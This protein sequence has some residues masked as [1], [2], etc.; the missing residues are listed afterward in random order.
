MTTTVE[1]LD[2]G[3]T[4]WRSGTPVP[5]S[6]LDT[7]YMVEHPDGGVIYFNNRKLFY[8]ANAGAVW[9]PLIQTLSTHR[10]WFT[11]FFIPDEIT[12]CD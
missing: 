6:S 10:T 5:A 11:A 9:Q 1:I 7:T 3:A 4:S 2:D 12:T 8:L